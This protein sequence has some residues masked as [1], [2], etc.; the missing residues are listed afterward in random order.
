MKLLVYLTILLLVGSSQLGYA[1]NQTDITMIVG[2]EENDLQTNKINRAYLLIENNG[3]KS[4]LIRSIEINSDKIKI[5][6]IEPASLPLESND[7]FLRLIINF[8][9]LNDG[10]YDSVFITVKYDLDGKEYVANLACPKFLVERNTFASLFKGWEALLSI[11][12]GIFT[13]LFSYF[14]VQYSERKRLKDSCIRYLQGSVT[15][16]IECHLR[17]INNPRRA[18][19]SLSTAGWD[20]ALKENLL[21]ALP[22]DERLQLKDYL[23]RYYIVVEKYNLES[24][25]YL[26]S[27]YVEELTAEATNAITAINN[28]YTRVS[29]RQR[30]SKCWSGILSVFTKTDNTSHG[31]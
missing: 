16:E 25:V 23:G 3:K 14:F 19:E 6:T 9:I 12:S 5:E 30:V 1:Q 7:T 10:N 15:N 2:L 29:W 31:A 8:S 11:G 17:Q 13:A 28:I 22:Q 21:F 24:D 18:G 20:N 4:C 27:S 26:Q